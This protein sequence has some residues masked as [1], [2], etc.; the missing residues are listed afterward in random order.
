MVSQV[1]LEQAGFVEG[2]ITL[3]TFEL[4]DFLRMFLRDVQINSFQAS[5]DGF[6][7]E[8]TVLLLVPRHGFLVLRVVL[9]RGKELFEAAQ[10]VMEEELGLVFPREGLR[11]L[12]EGPRELRVWV[13]SVFQAVVHEHGV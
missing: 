6:L 10:V 4:G 13:V 7:A 12:A 11:I 1:R 3:R 2:E 8:G 9:P 5:L